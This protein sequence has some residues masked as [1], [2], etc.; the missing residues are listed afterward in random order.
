HHQL[1]LMADDRRLMALLQ[2]HHCDI[3]RNHHHRPAEADR[4]QKLIFESLPFAAGLHAAPA[5][6]PEDFFWDGKSVGCESAGQLAIPGH[7][8]GRRRALR[9]P[10]THFHPRS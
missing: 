4:D 10:G 8:P 3:Q 7:K 1:F 2:H 5:H 9:T 6:V